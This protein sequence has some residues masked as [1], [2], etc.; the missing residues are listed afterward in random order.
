MTTAPQIAFQQR[1]GL[2][3]TGEVIE[4]VGINLLI[5]V[6]GASRKNARNR[7]SLFPINDM[8]NAVTNSYA[9]RALL[10]NY[11]APTYPVVSG[12]ADFS[13]TPSAA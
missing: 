11:G 1:N 9:I 7:T 8:G 2:R 12:A 4:Q 6:I 5:K 13:P 10:L 3:V